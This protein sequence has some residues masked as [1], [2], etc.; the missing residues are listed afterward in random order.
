MDE[1]RKVGKMGPFH[2]TAGFGRLLLL[3]GGCGTSHRVMWL[4]ET[5]L[6]PASLEKCCKGP[7]SLTVLLL[8]GTERRRSYLCSVL[9]NM[10]ILEVEL[11]D[12]LKDCLDF[13]PAGIHSG[14]ICVC[15]GT[16]GHTWLQD[17]SSHFLLPDQVTSMYPVCPP[18]KERVFHKWASPSFAEGGR[19]WAIWTLHSKD[20]TSTAGFRPLPRSV[21]IR[22]RCS[23]RL[24]LWEGEKI[25]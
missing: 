17:S 1:S 22:R 21:Q 16:E 10:L 6:L 9:G 8:V 25:G 4:Q 12:I 19:T 2:T 15:Q 5:P 13:L 11:K 7:A 14:L 20:T 23:H 24:S 3:T 18:S